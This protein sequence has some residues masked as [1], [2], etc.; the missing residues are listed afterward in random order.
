M[1]GGGEGRY[2]HMVI[3]DKLFRETNF[4]ILL[5]HFHGGFL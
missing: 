2:S 5:K 4:E 1:C 3:W